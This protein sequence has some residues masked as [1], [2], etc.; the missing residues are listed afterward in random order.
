MNI[1]KISYFI[2]GTKMMELPVYTQAYSTDKY[3]Y[4]ESLPA[5]TENTMCFW[6]WSHIKGGDNVRGIVSIATPGKL[7]NSS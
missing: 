6:F 7:C 1:E 4:Q 3:L 2:L 5:M